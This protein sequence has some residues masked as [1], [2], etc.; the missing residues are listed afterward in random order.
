MVRHTARRRVAHDGG[1]DTWRLGRRPAL[2]GLRGVA[3]LLV[4]ACHAGRGLTGAGI[5]GVM[6]FFVLSGFLITSLLLEEHAHSPIS[7]RAF[8]LRRARR[9][10]PAL[11]VVVV[12]VLVLGLW[13]ET[14]VGG[15]D[16]VSI[17]FYVSNWYQVGHP[18]INALSQTW[19]LAIEEQFYLVWPI[20]LMVAMRRGGRRLQHV[21]VAGTVLAFSAMAW[22]VST[23]HEGGLARVDVGAP[24]LLTG[25]ALAA[26]MHGRAEGRGSSTVATLGLLALVPLA[27][28]WPGR[29]PRLAL[30]IV[31]PM[32]T[33]VVI[34]A[35]VQRGEVSFLC[36]R[37][38]RWVGRRSYAIYL[39]HFPILW[40]GERYFRGLLAIAVEV[41][42]AFVLAELSWRFVESPVMQSARG[43]DSVDAGAGQVAVER[44]LR[45]DRA[46][47]ASRLAYMWAGRGSTDGQVLLRKPGPPG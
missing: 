25:C 21:A 40:T 19:S 33:A 11:A 24:A 27:I 6:V 17:V 12:L 8:Y 43:V 14:G 16:L 2:D 29:G 22:A 42:S 44:D 36:A 45:V 13:L 28:A 26:W 35:S 32:A 1:V 41:I 23:G 46:R 5:E 31:T 47:P 37:W 34:W 3:I 20:L 4:V 30:Q 18:T 10:F 7:L 9:L 38:L 15:G 39:W